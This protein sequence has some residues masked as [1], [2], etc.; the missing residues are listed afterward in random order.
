[1]SRRTIRAAI[2]DLRA[3][4]PSRRQ[5]MAGSTLALTGA[6]SATDAAV[7]ACHAWLEFEAEYE[8]L[9]QRWQAVEAHLI[10]HHNWRQLSR[11]QRA[12]MSESVVSL[13]VVYEPAF[14]TGHAGMVGPAVMPALPGD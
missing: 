8:D 13:N 5:L 7:E 3:N 11:R 10:R 14:V 4:G 12:A 1:M 6:P 9:I 2:A